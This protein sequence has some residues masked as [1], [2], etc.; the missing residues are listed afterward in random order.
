VA[1][2]VLQMNLPP[3]ASLSEDLGNAGEC[4]LS[5][6][7]E[8]NDLLAMAGVRFSVKIGC[9]LQSEDHNAADMVIAIDAPLVSVGSHCQAV[10]YT[11]RTSRSNRA[12]TGLG[13]MLAAVRA[14]A[15]TLPGPRV[16]TRG[17]APTTEPPTTLE[18]GPGP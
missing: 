11:T 7:V 10:V 4:R 2:L 3:Q 17:R 5:F 15:A 18:P 16:P 9:P 8:P 6:V 13:T 12:R 1:T 14:W